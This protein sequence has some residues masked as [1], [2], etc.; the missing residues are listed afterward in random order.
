MA[1]QQS[2]ATA[3]GVE[4]P[5]SL[6]FHFPP[7]GERRGGV[8]LVHGFSATP[9]E[10][11]QTGA[12]LAVAGWETLGVR[13]P[14][15]GTSAADLAGRRLEE[16]QAEVESGYQLLAPAGPPVLLGVS[17]GALLVA[18]LAARKPAAGLIM[19][20]PF[21]RLRHRLAPWAGLLRHVRPYHDVEVPTVLRPFYYR[22]RPLTAV[23]QL[24]RLLRRMP[25]VLPAVTAPA[26][27]INSEGDRTIDLKSV[28]PL[29]RKLGSRERTVVMLGSESP[30][31]LTT[32]ENP[33]RAEVM[34][35]IL[36]FLRGLGTG[37]GVGTAP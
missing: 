31:V 8:L 9:W 21:L 19:L 15:H 22:R 18:E 25:G 20:S 28:P 10:V 26:L 34:A 11:R 29:L 23:H 16:W 14:G 13:L 7:C 17:T 3:E 33:R 12:E 4:E 32:M 35:L 2:L 1:R 27:V 6:P 24:N 37:T 5:S 30:H 36:E